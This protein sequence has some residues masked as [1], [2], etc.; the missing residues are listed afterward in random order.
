MSG[1]IT[2]RLSSDAAGTMETPVLIPAGTGTVTN[3]D[4]REGDLSGINLD[5]SDGSFWVSQEFAT[6]SSQFNTGSWGEA[7][8]N[9]TVAA[10]TTGT[11]DLA[12]T[13]SGPM[14]AT[15]GDNNLTYT[16]TVTSAGPDAAPSTV[17]TDTLGA[18]LTFVS[19]TTSQGTFTQ[20]GSTVTFNLGTIANG[21]SATVTV[22]AQAT[23][24]GT[25]TDS[26][27]VTS[28]AADPTPGD[29]S[30]SASTTVAEPAIVVSA[31][32]TTTSKRFSGTVATFTHANGVEPA[33]AFVA[34][35][36]WG[37]GTTSTGSITLSGTTYTVT[38]THRYS[39]SGSHT[40]TTTVVESGGAPNAPESV[41]SAPT[42]APL[43]LAA[44]PPSQA[45]S[46]APGGTTTPLSQ[47]TGRPGPAAAGAGSA[48][49][50]L[51]PQRL[52]GGTPRDLSA[53][54]PPAGS[55]GSRGDGAGIG[56]WAIDLPLSPPK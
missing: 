5:P 24:D 15:E 29:N 16:F 19:A 32:I 13:G 27:S 22:T 23:E 43:P 47:G 6:H 28:G 42:S 4:G 2:G 48:V 56:D 35:I 11:A 21:G 3:S 17:L 53:G 7:V 12:L 45:P 40:I 54:G 18:N 33:S 1:Y 50:N 38:G 34:T 26:A 52:T 44:V 46:G 14:T 55:A 20:S 8:A 25:L 10:A 39:G 30:A 51:G 9:F 37:D 49:A 36:H 31:P 41:P